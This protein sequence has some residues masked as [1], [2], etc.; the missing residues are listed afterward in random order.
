MKTNCNP[1]RSGL[2]VPESFAAATRDMNELFDRL[3][4][5]PVRGDSPRTWSAPASVWEDEENHYVELDVPG[6]RAD[7]LDVTVDDGNLIVA[8]ERKS[9]EGR[10]YLHNERRFGQVQRTITLP[11]TVDAE[12]IDAN[13]QDGVLLVVMKK[14]P[15][16]QPRKVDV[17]T[18]PRES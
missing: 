1:R 5:G 11:D 12:S 2:F 6:V 16:V 7:D 13:Y 3:L 14:R 8:A 18:T 15:E 17:K 9:T 10:R 4:D